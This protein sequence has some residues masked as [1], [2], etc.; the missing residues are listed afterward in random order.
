H[1][2]GHPGIS[3]RRPGSGRPGKATSMTERPAVCHLG[4]RRGPLA[5]SVVCAA[6]T[7]TT[8]TL[9]GNEGRCAAPEPRSDE[10]TDAEELLGVVRFG[11]VGALEQRRPCDVDTSSAREGGE[12]RLARRVVGGDGRL[13]VG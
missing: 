4:V 5:C 10:R 3:R 9:R 7:L 13:D 2:T 11:E 1:F 12:E 8:M 6:P